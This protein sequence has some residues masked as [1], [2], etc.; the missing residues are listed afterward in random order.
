MLRWFDGYGC[1][2]AQCSFMVQVRLSAE[3]CAR[4][5]RRLRRQGHCAEPGAAQEQRAQVEG[6]VQDAAVA[7]LVCLL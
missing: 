1:E 3:R 5:W 6:V 7:G 2:S 4:L